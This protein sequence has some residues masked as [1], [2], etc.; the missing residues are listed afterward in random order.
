MSELDLSFEFGYLVVSKAF[1]AAWEYCPCV[2]FSITQGSWEWAVIPAPS[3][4]KVTLTVSIQA[5]VVFSTMLLLRTQS[6]IRQSGCLSQHSV[7]PNDLISWTAIEPVHAYWDSLLETC[8]RCL[9]VEGIISSKICGEDLFI[10]N[11]S[12][13]LYC[14]VSSHLPIQ[15]R[16]FIRMLNKLK[17]N[18][19][20]YLS[21]MKV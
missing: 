8:F 12:R 21:F 14:A 16:S 18:F 7:R 2:Q 13:N 17:I 9:Y 1:P 3:D 4:Q 20:C 19:S 6:Y 10:Y 5:K 11:R 15:V